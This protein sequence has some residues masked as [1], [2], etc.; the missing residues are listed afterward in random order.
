[1]GGFAGI[2]RGALAGVNDA[3]GN[4][5]TAAA[6]NAQNDRARQAKQDELKAKVFPHAVAIKGLQQKLA[7]TTDP[8]EQAAITHDIA[9]NL[10]EV[11]Q[12]IHPDENPQGNFFERGITD[13]LHLSSLKNRVQA[14][15]KR[16]AEGVNQD[17]SQ[18]QS[19]AQGTVPFDQTPA[20]LLEKQKAIDAQA[21]ADKRAKP[22]LKNFRNPA[23]NEEQVFDANDPASIPQGWVMAGTGS[24]SAKP[25]VKPLEAGGVP[26]G[27]EADGKTYYPSQMNDPNVPPEVKETWK[28][29]QDAKKAKQDETDKRDRERDEHFLQA[30]ANIANRMGRTEA[31]QMQMADFREQE[32]VFK[33]LDTEARKAEDEANTYTAMYDDP[34]TNKS[35]ADTALIAAYTSVIA[36]GGRKTQAELTM[37]RNIGNFKLNW[38]QR[39]KKLATGELPVEL[40][41]LYLDFMK[42][43]AKTAREDADKAKPDLPKVVVPTGQGKSKLDAT[44]SAQQG[45][46]PGKAIVQH[47]PSTGKYR[48]STDGGKTWQAGQPPA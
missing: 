39:A 27:V 29:I 30:Q 48:Y 25:T 8:H 14:E 16:R 38:E 18:A 9:R 11:R 10:A 1:M 24:A 41:S 43:S 17:Q 42:S 46:N 28:T 40:R 6:L 34:N 4:T 22:M 36:K 26:Y 23:T 12:M 2:V 13:K 32:G 21:L 37:A 7:A 47:S 3:A 33:T 15:G 44:R 31:F 19:I 45:G 5:Q 20:A 35:A